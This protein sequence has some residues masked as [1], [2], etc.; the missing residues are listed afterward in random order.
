MAG[1]KGKE[2]VLVKYDRVE[3]LVVRAKVR[4]INLLMW[5]DL[6]SLHSKKTTMMIGKMMVL[7]MSQLKA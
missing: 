6:E 1:E 2:Y 7:K 5:M 4:K 3:G